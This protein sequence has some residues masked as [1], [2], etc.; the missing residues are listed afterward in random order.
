MRNADVLILS[1]IGTERS[2]GRVDFFYFFGGGGLRGVVD[3]LRGEGV[4]EK[5]DFVFPYFRK[6][7]NKLAFVYCVR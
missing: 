2:K 1:S 6:P 3:L 5:Q 7:K 4:A